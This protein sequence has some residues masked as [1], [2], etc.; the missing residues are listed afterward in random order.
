MCTMDQLNWGF[1]NSTYI[2]SLEPY[3]DVVKLL[4]II[5]DSLKVW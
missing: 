4:Q 5:A 3:C 1:K 2:R